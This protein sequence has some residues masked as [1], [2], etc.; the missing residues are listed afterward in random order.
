[1][2][3]QTKMS[4][5]PGRARNVGRPVAEIALHSVLTES[6]SPPTRGLGCRIWATCQM[7]KCLPFMAPVPGSPSSE[8]YTQTWTLPTP[9]CLRRA[10]SPS[11]DRLLEE[12]CGRAERVPLSVTAHFLCPLLRDTVWG[13]PPHEMPCCLSYWMTQQ[14]RFLVW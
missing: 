1:M 11:G 2:S 10:G 3:V 14:S 8:I 9:R 6:K 4:D 7:L 13:T 5:G 12:V